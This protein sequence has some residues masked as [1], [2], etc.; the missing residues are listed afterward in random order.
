MAQGTPVILLKQD[1]DPTELTLIQLQQ[2]YYDV[3][4]EKM[5]TPIINGCSVEAN[6]Y[7]LHEFQETAEELTF[8][9]G[10]E[11]FKYFCCIL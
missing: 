1:F 5:G 3:T 7:G 4:K 6:L 10:D 2:K 8:D 11:L 9:T